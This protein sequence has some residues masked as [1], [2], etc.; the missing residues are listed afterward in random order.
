MASSPLTP[1]AVRRLARLSRLSVDDA[2][3]PRLAADLEKILG[4]VAMLEGVDTTGIETTAHV[5]VERMPLRP[6]EP[7]ES[8]SHDAALASAPRKTEAGFA[9]PAFVEE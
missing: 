9:V 5:A 2:S 3:L 6:D 7:H 4:Y 1:D 8:L